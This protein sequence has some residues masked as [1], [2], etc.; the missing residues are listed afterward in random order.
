MTDK[1]IYI[2]N[3]ESLLESID[4]TTEPQ[5]LAHYQQQLVELESNY[6]YNKMMSSIHD[7]ESELWNVWN[8]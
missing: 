2:T 5:L 7:M 1:E 4:D 6:H 8:Q 3:R